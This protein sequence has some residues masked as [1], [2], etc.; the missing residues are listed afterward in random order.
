MLSLS[1]P[2]LVVGFT[3]AIALAVIVPEI[4]ST[5]EM[6]VLLGSVGLGTLGLCGTIIGL[7]LP[8]VEGVPGADD[9]IRVGLITDTHFWLADSNKDYLQSAPAWSGPSREDYLAD[10]PSF[11]VAAFRA[12]PVLAAW[13]VIIAVVAFTRVIVRRLF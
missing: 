3:T 7:A 12:W 4:D 5:L 10:R 1:V 11:L 13:V 6:S 9:S 8:Y 2:A